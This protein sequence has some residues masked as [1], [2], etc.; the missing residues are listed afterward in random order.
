VPFFRYRRLYKALEPYL[1][2]SGVP[3]KQLV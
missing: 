3:V 2:S 1:V